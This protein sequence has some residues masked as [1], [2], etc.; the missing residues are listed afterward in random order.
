MDEYLK[1][2]KAL[3]DKTRLRIVLMLK[4]KP[5]CVC[6]IREI[7]GTSMSTISN[8]LKILKEAGIINSQKEDRYINYRLDNT[9]KAVIQIVDLLDNLDGIEI[10]NDKQKA[11]TTDR[12]NIG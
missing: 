3:G 11:C 6:E 8:H 12:K 1:V 10:E 2:F 9:R 5:M 4:V 7:I